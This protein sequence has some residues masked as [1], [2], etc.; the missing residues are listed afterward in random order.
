[1]T[2]Q[3]SET[4]AIRERID[5]LDEAINRARDMA[6]GLKGGAAKQEIDRANELTAERVKLVRRL[7]RL[8][9]QE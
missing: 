8:E 9:A 4:R 3:V 2:A 1:M 6:Q 5:R 7:E